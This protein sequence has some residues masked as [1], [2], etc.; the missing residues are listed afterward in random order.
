MIIYAV[1]DALRM[2]RMHLRVTK[3]IKMNSSNE[4]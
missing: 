2:P 4:A 1:K 3:M